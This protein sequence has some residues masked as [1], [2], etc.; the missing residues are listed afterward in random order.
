[1]STTTTLTSTKSKAIPTNQ[2]NEPSSVLVA[3]EPAVAAITAATDDAKFQAT[4]RGDRAGT[5]KL[6]G[7]PTF[8]DPYEKR[9]WMK[10]HMAAAFRFF[11]K[12]GYGEGI[13]GHISMRGIHI[14]LTNNFN[15]TQYSNVC[16]TNIVDI[17]Q[18]QS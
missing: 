15:A 17:L 8:S 5:L 10:E 1:M 11:G 14:Y 13:S 9:K 3:P 16:T 4:A 18:T 7:I 12:L 2:P 6:R